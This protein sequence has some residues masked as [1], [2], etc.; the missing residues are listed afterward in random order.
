MSQKPSLKQLI[1]RAKTTAVNITGVSTP[2]TDAIAAMVGGG[3]YGQYAYMDYLFRQ[4]NPETADEEWLY[5]WASRFSVDRILPTYASG[6]VLFSNT[7]SVVSVPQG[8]IIATA[9]NKQYQVTT[10]TNSDQPVPVVALTAGSEYN[11]SAGI[12]LYLTSAVTGLNP[13]S[14][15]SDT[16]SAGAEIE[17]L[18][19]WRNRIVIAF[20]SQQ[21]IGRLEDYKNWS[22]SAHSDVD[23]AFAL[24]NTP[25]N[26]FVT[27]YIGQREN[28]PIVS[29]AVKTAVQDYIETKRLAGCHV[30]VNHPNTKPL[31]ITFSDVADITTRNTIETEMQ[32]YI[33]SRL[34]DQ[35]AI[36]PGEIIAVASTV[37]TGFSLISP[38]ASVTPATD[39]VIVLGTVTWQ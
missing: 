25:V 19:H 28:N 36:T 2:A 20:N 10:A 8:T 37:T 14:I 16:I 34:G 23:F 17:D 32:N 27:V 22:I 18:E 39:E 35:A 30:V 4:L 7:S 1:D 9:D 26:G 31:D 38:I 11:L 29:D 21:S 12:A 33:N 3:N 15:T 6:N 13:E 24:D 5:L